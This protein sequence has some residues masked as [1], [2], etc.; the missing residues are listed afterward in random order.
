MP[1]AVTPA[2]AR[3]RA[4]ARLQD[5]RAKAACRVNR[6]VG[7]LR[8]IREEGLATFEALRDVR[9]RANATIDNGE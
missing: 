9:D 3:L 4:S 2:P 5:L 6:S 8:E 7:D 1:S